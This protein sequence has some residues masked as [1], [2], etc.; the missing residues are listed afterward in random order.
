MCVCVREREREREGGREKVSECKLTFTALDPV[1]PRVIKV[2]VTDIATSPVPSTAA[3]ATT[4]LSECCVGA[5][6]WAGDRGRSS[7]R[8]SSRH[9][10][11]CVDT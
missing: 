5:A 10:S 9:G 1:E 11:W 7:G 2:W 4:A 8:H 6:L 3:E